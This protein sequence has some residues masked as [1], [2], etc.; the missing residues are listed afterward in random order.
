MS[1][2]NA[3]KVAE[4]HRLQAVAERAGFVLGLRVNKLGGGVA[5]LVLEAKGKPAELFRSLDRVARAIEGDPTP[6]S[7]WRG[8]AARE[9][10][11]DWC[12]QCGHDYRASNADCEYERDK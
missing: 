4:F 5:H 1:W 8:L 9:A 11:N 12:L 2:Q 3:D 7:D 6:K 10:V